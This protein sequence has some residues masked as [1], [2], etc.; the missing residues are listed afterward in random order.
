MPASRVQNSPSTSRRSAWHVVVIYLAALCQGLTL[1]AVP[2]LS[3]V[4]K[5][6]LHLSDAQYGATFLPQVV[7]TAIAALLGGAV[8]R[9]FSLKALLLLALIANAGAEGLL[10]LTPAVDAMWVFPTVFASC[11]LLGIGFGLSAAPLNS[12]PRLLFPNRGDSALVA[13]HTVL[14]AGLCL[15]PLIANWAVT[16]GAWTGYPVALAVA[17][18]ALGG[19]VVGLNLPDAARPVSGKQRPREW[20]NRDFTLLLAIAVLYAFAEGT[21]SSWAIV[22]L[23]EDRG[24]GAGTA[25][26]AL[27]VF[28][29]ALV[30]GRLVV[31]ALLVWVSS[32]AVWQC[33]PVLMMGAFAV[34]PLVSTAT[35]GLLAFAG[36]GL[37]CSAF[38]PL[39]VARA[40][41]RFPADEALMGSSL[42]AA[43]MIGVGV[44]TFTIATLRGILGMATL[45][46]Y[47]IAYPLLVLVLCR[48][49]LRS[50]TSEGRLPRPAGVR[51]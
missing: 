39:T 48:I 7:A 30:I 24:I 11:A 36:A 44:G 9:R 6:T 46:H 26:L 37:A 28:W 14:G 35:S 25:A 33:L 12:L 13:L 10:L 5:A 47:S 18:L 22:Y 20:V 2:A 27:S 16:H 4:L 17:M 38:F 51:P 41:T 49:L 1:V 15:G 8:A 31:S 29:G 21:L 45:Y 19:M 23:H 32:A 3:P 50:H 34:L 43:L 42:T 40:S